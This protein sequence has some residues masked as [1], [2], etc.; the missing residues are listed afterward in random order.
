M[1]QEP[2][3]VE[4]SITDEQSIVI[5]ASKPHQQLPAGPVRIRRLSIDSFAESPHTVSRRRG[6]SPAS[7]SSEN[8]TDNDRN[9]ED[10]D[11][12]QENNDSLE[13]AAELH[14]FKCYF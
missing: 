7:G 1:H 4:T 6:Y 10:D 9:Y 5:S 3:S 14:S 13:H 8:A 11:Y 2:L 12:D